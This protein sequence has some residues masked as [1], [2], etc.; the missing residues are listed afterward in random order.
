[1]N[2]KNPDSDMMMYPLRVWILQ[3]IDPRLIHFRIEVKKRKIRF[4]I[5]NPDLDFSQ[6]NAPL[7]N[8]LL[9]YFPV[10]LHVLGAK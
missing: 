6:R 10:I 1:M 8:P 2:P 4:W 9:S 7:D 5:K 3:I